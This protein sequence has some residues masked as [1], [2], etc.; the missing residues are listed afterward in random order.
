MCI[1]CIPTSRIYIAVDIPVDIKCAAVDM[2]D[3]P[4]DI[5]CIAVDMRDIPVEDCMCIAAWAF[6]V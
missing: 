5:K 3:I 6:L 1:Y 2:R 4:V